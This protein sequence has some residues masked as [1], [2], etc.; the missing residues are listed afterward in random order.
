MLNPWQQKVKV[1][2]NVLLASTLCP[3]L[4]ACGGPPA[5]GDLRPVTPALSLSTGKVLTAIGVKPPRENDTGVDNAVWQ[6]RR[7]A[8]GLTNLLAES[9]YETGKFRL[10]EEKELPQRQLIEELV[11]LFSSA[12]RPEP[13]EL[14]LASIGRRLEADLLAYGRV[15]STRLSGQRTVFGPLGRYQQT[16]RINI[17]VC[18]YEISTQQSLCREGEGMAQQE[19][20]GVVYEFRNNRPDFEKTAAGL[21]TKQAVTSAV[22][23]LMASI[24]FSP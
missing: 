7:V 20:M 11:E 17:D 6:D 10:V 14:E 18:L 5:R 2:I 12:S 19:G 22:E 4:A 24:R 23:A 9:F 13:S 21:A 8:F 1:L 16:L 3:L 15:G